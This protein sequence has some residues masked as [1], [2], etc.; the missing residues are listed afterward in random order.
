M[1]FNVFVVFGVC[2]CG[3]LGFACCWV[4]F[5]WELDARVVSFHCCLLGSRFMALGAWGL[6]L[7]IGLLAFRAL[8]LWLFSSSGIVSCA[9]WILLKFQVS[10]FC[11]C[12]D[13]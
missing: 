2:G 1:F 13:F 12:L 8:V 6:S 10:W 9:A 7:L 5:F 4:G 3:V 11:A